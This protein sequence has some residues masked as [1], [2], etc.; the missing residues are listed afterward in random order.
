MGKTMLSIFLTEEL[1]RQ[2]NSSEAVLLYYFCEGQDV[3]R[4][5]AVNILRGLLYSFVRQRPKLIKWILPDFEVRDEA[6]FTSSSIEATWGINDPDTGPVYCV[7]DGLD[8]CSKT[9]LE[10]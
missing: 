6:L 9:S 8:E 3:K 2:K 1:E 7:A 10:D 5:S 4:N